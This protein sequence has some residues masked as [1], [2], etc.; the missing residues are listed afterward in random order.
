MYGFS[1]FGTNAYGSGRQSAMLGPVVK[2]A[3]RIVQNGYNATLALTLRFRNLT[4]GDPA[5]NQNTL[6]L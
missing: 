1:G 5:T 2:L 4:V 3:M 6:Q